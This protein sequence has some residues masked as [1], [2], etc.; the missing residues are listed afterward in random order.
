MNLTF[1]DGVQLAGRLVQQNDCR[2]VNESPGQR[3][4]LALA[5]RQ[6]SAS[7]ADHCF[8]CHRHCDNVFMNAGKL[9]CPD[10]IRHRNVW[11]IER[12]VCANG[13]TKQV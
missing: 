12:N 8:V 10:D 6:G 11:I 3:D 5:S 2:L 13:R 9:G 7:F 4:A 1:G